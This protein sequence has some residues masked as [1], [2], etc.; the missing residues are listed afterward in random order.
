MATGNVCASQGTTSMVTALAM[1]PELFA[2]NAV[3]ETAFSLNRPE[4]WK[5]ILS[6][7]YPS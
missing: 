3:A 1:A 2:N 6:L 4:P 5:T 7:L